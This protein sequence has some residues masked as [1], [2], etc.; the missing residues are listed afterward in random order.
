MLK[1]ILAAS[2]ASVL[3]LT[4]LAATA[5][6]DDAAV[7]SSDYTLE[8]LPGTY[9]TWQ[10]G[11]T[12]AHI[13]AT[14][15][16]SAIGDAIA[17]TKTITASDANTVIPTIADYVTAGETADVT[18]NLLTSGDPA[19]A[20][21]YAY[22]DSEGNFVSAPTT[23]TTIDITGGITKGLKL[24][25]ITKVPAA[26]PTGTIEGCSYTVVNNFVGFG[27]I[28][29]SANPYNKLAMGLSV[30]DAN[31][32]GGTLKL[33]EQSDF[34]MT[35][36]SM[37]ATLKGLGTDT[38]TLAGGTEEEVN[39][40]RT[41]SGECYF[42]DI[43]GGSTPKGLKKSTNSASEWVTDVKGMNVSFGLSAS[44]TLTLLKPEQS[45]VVVE[46]DVEMNNSNWEKLCKSAG[47]TWDV[48]DKEWTDVDFSKLVNASGDKLL[49]TFL[50]IEGTSVIDWANVTGTT[51]DVQVGGFGIQN[52]N[53]TKAT[54][55]KVGDGK[56][57]EH[58]NYFV[59]GVNQAN[60]GDVITSSNVNV[61]VGLGTTKNNI[62][63]N[64]NN[65]G[66][67]TFTFD[68]D[69]RNQD[70][71]NPYIIWKGG[72]GLVNL[73]LQLT[74]TFEG[75]AKEL[76]LSFPAGLTWAEGNTNFYNSFVM[77]FNLNY[78]NS[79]AIQDGS[80]GL[81]QLE[82]G[83]NV[84]GT[85]A[86]N[87]FFKTGKDVVGADNYGAHLVKITF[88]A[89]EKAP[90]GGN[91]GGLVSDPSD[92]T[93]SESTPSTPSTGDNSGNKGDD[94]AN[95]STGVAVAVAPVVLVAAAAAVVIYKKRK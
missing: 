21:K 87:S 17:A 83:T 73:P 3:A 41:G 89:N 57:T 2:T 46:F 68:K 5:M 25:K 6:A 91:Q 61:A 27:A 81:P 82:Q 20:G 79:F 86:R 69:I 14:L 44:S 22:L 53:S 45:E 31:Y 26:P 18:A 63:K 23:A 94:N 40:E 70:I 33:Y 84:A 77:S 67:V 47:I 34:K 19:E 90:E 59:S 15:K 52:V 64:L 35:N 62:L 12:S 13:T 92:S 48:G 29:D 55:V 66:T 7:K 36:I 80:Q 75:T 58:S 54:D 65:G 32:D 71:F 74:N 60:N 88:K 78:E 4:A 39:K 51:N 42:D 76:T 93:P 72:S 16:S 30:R 37:K 10:E 38:K 49:N 85:A 9:S 8:L 43:Q 50:G 1:K 28:E 24:V 56:S 11:K 95:P